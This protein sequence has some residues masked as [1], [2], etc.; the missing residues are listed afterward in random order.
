MTKK[1]KKA[2][3]FTAADDLRQVLKMI[4]EKLD[5]LG[6]SMESCPPLFYPEAIHNLYVWTAKASRDCQAKHSWHG[7][8]EKEV[9]KC[10]MARIK[11]IQV[12]NGS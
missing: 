7:N 6:I 4:K 12:E 9:V 10:I 8:N 5:G 2:K 3:R 11:A 1:P